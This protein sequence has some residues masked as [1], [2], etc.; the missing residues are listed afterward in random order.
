MGIVI[1]LALL[2]TFRT[3]WR[4]I[5]AKMENKPVKREDQTVIRCKE[6]IKIEKPMLKCSRHRCLHRY[7]K[8]SRCHFHR[9]AQI[10]AETDRKQQKICK[11]FISLTPLVADKVSVLKFCGFN[12]NALR[13]TN[14]SKV[15][16]C[17][18]LVHNTYK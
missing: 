6:P 4:I 1:D 5:R 3:L 10:M 15:L 11:F 16:V 18:T 13:S 12:P 7:S 2:S 17:L 14:Y 8:K 9:T